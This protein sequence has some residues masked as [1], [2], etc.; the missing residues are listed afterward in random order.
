MFRLAFW[1]AGIVL[2]ALLPALPPWFLLPALA[3]MLWPCWWGR[4]QGWL[5][6]LLYCALGLSYASW[7]AELRLAQSLDPRLVGRSLTLPVVVRGLAAPG[8]FGV[9][10][11]AEVLLPPPGVPPL[12]AL[13]DYAQRDWPAGSYWRITVKLRPPHGAA[14]VAGFDAERWYWSEGIQA[15]GSVAKGRQPLPSTPPDLQARLDRQR[16]AIVQRLQQASP[17]GRDLALVVALSVGAQQWLGRAEWGALAATGLTH[18]VSVSGLHISLVAMLVTV[19]VRAL[20]RGGL[21]LPAWLS[22]WCGMLAAIGYALL[23]GFSV[24][25]QRTVWMLLLAVTALS[26]QRG[27]SGLQVWLAALTVVLL[28][29]PFAVLAPGFWLSFLLVG[30][31]VAGETGLREPAARWWRAVQAQWR[32]TL[33]SLLPL[34]YL[35]GSFPLLSPLANALAIPFVSCLLTPLVLL[36][37]LLP[38][39]A[40]LWLACRLAAVF[41]FGVDWLAQWPPFVRP[42]LPWP[43]LPAAVLGSLMLVLPLGRAWQTLA[44]T[45]LLPLLLY[46]A[47]RPPAGELWAEVLDVGQGSAMLLQTAQHDALFDTGAGDAGRVLLPVLRA[48][49]IGRLDA[50]WLSH[51]DIDHDGAAD[52]LLP[53]LPVQQLY[54]GQA[55][56]AAAWR[57]QPCLAGQSWVWDGVRFDVLSPQ[58]GAQGEDNA[59]SCVLRVATPHQALLVT[60][61]AP[62]AVEAGLLARYGRQLRSDVLLLGHHGSRTATGSNWL[63]VVRPVLAV[64][65]AGYLN[66]YRHPHREVLARVAAAGVP[67]WRTDLHGAIR[68]QLGRTLHWQAARPGWQAYWAGSSVVATTTLPQP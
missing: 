27:L 26:L 34:L 9:R 49:G 5:C 29:D 64:A 28:L 11:R 18:I 20:R 2:C 58:A 15:T 67:L 46:R 38:L 65:S 54:R 41:W 13:N 7:R 47:P 37:M 56:S 3:L 36:S 21:P 24:P 10:W 12:L 33:V 35:F 62:L 44:L 50:L 25:T 66:R 48:R 16:Q 60:G 57:G 59:L 14:N 39:E 19:W 30:A 55:A 6:A 1:C 42:L 31:L 51:H 22:R 52:S 17:P 68:L 43:L 32:V 53:A 23:A 63:Q 4:R 40:L 45:A 8:E 61:D